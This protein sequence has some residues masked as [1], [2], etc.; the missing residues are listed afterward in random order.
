MWDEK[1]RIFPLSSLSDA[2]ACFRG[3]RRPAG[4]D[5]SGW[6]RL[7]YVS[8]P[9]WYFRYRAHLACV[10][11]LV[12]VPLDLVFVTYVRLDFPNETENS[13][14]SND[15]PIPGVVTHWQFVECD[16]NDRTLPVDHSRRY[17][18]RLW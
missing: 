2:S 4:E 11:E 5:D 8:H 6:D 15:V 12:A 16:A 7:A 10:A 18:K 17:R 3:I 14:A 1:L 9:R 13:R